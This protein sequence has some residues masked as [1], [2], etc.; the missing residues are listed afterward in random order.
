[1]Q[2]RTTQ[3]SLPCIIKQMCFGVKCTLNVVY[4][5]TYQDAEGEVASLVPRLLPDFISQ[6]IGIIAA[7]QAGNG[8]LG[9]Y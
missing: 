9:L 1:M 3:G 8:G 6:P 7:S 2:A 5:A 4:T